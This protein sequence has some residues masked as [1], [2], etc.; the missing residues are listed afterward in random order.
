MSDQPHP[1]LF[2]DYVP[3]PRPETEQDRQ[4]T[5]VAGK[6]GPTVLTFVQMHGPGGQFH[7]KDLH[8][9]VG[10]SVAPASADRILRFLRR[11]GLFDYEIV[12]RRASLY[13]ITSIAREDAA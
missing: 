6:I 9:F 11:A 13:Q 12:N 5:R 3:P 7:A 1:D 2:N 4:I 10:P 8:D